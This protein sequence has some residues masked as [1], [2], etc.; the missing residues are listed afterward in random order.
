[1]VDLQNLVMRKVLKRRGHELSKRDRSNA[2]IGVSEDTEESEDGEFD[3]AG[4]FDDGDFDDDEDSDDTDD[5]EYS[6]D[7]DLDEGFEE[8]ENLGDEPDWSHLEE[9]ETREDGTAE[10]S[11]RVSGSRY[12]RHPLTA[13]NDSIDIGGSSSK[14][15]SKPLSSTQRHTG[16]PANPPFESPGPNSVRLDR[17]KRRPSTDLSKESVKRG[18]YAQEVCCPDLLSPRTH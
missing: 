9:L 10:P 12:R 3:D 6:D 18:N 11:P 4:E 5:A 17:S 13:E 16:T 1:L 14:N 2:V 8:I 7:I 15:P